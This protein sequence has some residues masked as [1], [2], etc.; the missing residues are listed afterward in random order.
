MACYWDYER[1]LTKF[2][3]T[4]TR[5]IAKLRDTIKKRFKARHCSLNETMIPWAIQDITSEINNYLKK[6][7]ALLREEYD[8]VAVNIA[9]VQRAIEEDN[10]EAHYIIVQNR[11]RRIHKFKRI[12]IGGDLEH[13][14]I[15]LR[16]VNSLQYPSPDKVTNLWFWYTEQGK[17]SIELEITSV[18]EKTD[19][20]LTSLRVAQEVQKLSWLL[21]SVLNSDHIPVLPSFNLIWT[22]LNSSNMFV[23]QRSDPGD[24]LWT[25]RDSEAGIG[26][27]IIR[28]QARTCPV[29]HLYIIHD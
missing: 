5:G 16:Y 15:E 28:C 9:L 2:E 14:L 3:W 11:R 18:L 1:G 8:N 17:D 29:V 6:Q 24:Y 7:P 27:Q 20:L 25:L 13:W 21:P 10:A 12:Y 22:A 4:S 26:I 19:R 23:E